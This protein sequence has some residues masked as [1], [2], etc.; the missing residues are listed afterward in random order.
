M[1]A[2][3]GNAKCS[4]ALETYIFADDA[5]GRRFLDALVAARHRGARVRVLVDALGSITLP[6]AFWIP[7]IHAGGEF[8]WFNAFHA[9]ERYGCRNHRKLLVVDGES[10]FI[11][12]FNIGQEYHG[13]GVSEGWRDL[14]LEVRGPVVAA[15]AATFDQLY[16]SADNRPP[17]FASLRKDPEAEVCGDGWTLLLTGPGRGH[18]ALR[19][20]LIRDLSRARQ[21]QILCAYF[22]PTWR[23]RRAL[24][25]AAR[26]GA[27]VHLVLAGKSDVALSQLASQSL[28]GK[29]MRAGVRIDEYQPQILHA[30]LFVIDDVVYAGSANLDAR[31]LKLNYELALRVA[32]PAVAAGGR[33]LFQNDLAVSR[34]VD[35]AEWRKRRWWRRLLEKAAYFIVARVDPYVTHL[36]WRNRAA[37]AVKA[38]GAVRALEKIPRERRAGANP[39]SPGG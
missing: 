16:A 11:G 35:P 17:A 25:Q 39:R 37:R 22:V 5:L 32:D 31:S 27:D 6:T 2:A 4:V 19:R 14:G 28:Y 15:L 10:A 18:R 29:L 38:V 7:L 8:R 33:L 30:K 21:V 3:I 34:R 1:L 23:L 9:R 13:D 26:R 20:A 36:G 24:M 12:G